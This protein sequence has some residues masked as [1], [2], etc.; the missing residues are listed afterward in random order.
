MVE[1]CISWTAEKIVLETGMDTLLQPA[2]AM[3]L[4]FVLLRGSPG[5]TLERSRRKDHSR[6]LTDLPQDLHNGISLP[7]RV[8]LPSSKLSTTTNSW[9]KTQS[10]KYW[11]ATEKQFWRV[12]FRIVW[13][14]LPQPPYNKLRF[15][16]ASFISWDHFLFLN[17]S[18]EL[19]LN[20]SFFLLHKL[21][22]FITQIPWKQI[23]NY[24]KSYEQ[25]WKQSVGGL[26]HLT[27][28]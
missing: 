26:Y 24:C 28:F 17:L 6:W 20:L 1:F 8:W 14:I 11:P 5:L 16:C 7:I 4:S 27:H 12:R 10:L 2:N 9:N 21:H 25:A 23:Q 15:F 22:I 18:T 13:S 3:S 19:N